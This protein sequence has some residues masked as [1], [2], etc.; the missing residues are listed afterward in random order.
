METNYK[1]LLQKILPNIRFNG[2]DKLYEINYCK[3][4]EGEYH[5]VIYVEYHESTPSSR[6]IKITKTVIDTVLYNEILSIKKYINLDVK[7]III[8]SGL[9]QVL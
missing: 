7:N 2:C 5:M 6:G 9:N 3:I 1:K 8:D 4:I